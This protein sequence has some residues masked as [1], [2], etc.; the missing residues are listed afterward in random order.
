MET[1]IKK[2]RLMLYVSLGFIFIET[3]LGVGTIFSGFMYRSD[4]E[5]KITRKL[6]K[7]ENPEKYESIT[8]DKDSLAKAKFEKKYYK[9]KNPI[10]VTGGCLFLIFAFLHAIPT[11]LLILL[12]KDV[13]GTEGETDE[14][15]PGEESSGDGGGESGGDEGGGEIEF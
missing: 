13:G 8:G 4:E 10:L 5:L 11:G 14:E 6:L 3:I 2:I 1:N 12:T 15:E 9:T 7:V